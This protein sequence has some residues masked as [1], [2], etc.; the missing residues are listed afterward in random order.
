MFDAGS[1]PAVEGVVGLLLRR[2]RSVFARPVRDEGGCTA[3]AAVAE[4]RRVLH[5]AVHAR[6]PVGTGVMAVAGQW[7]SGR[8]GQSCVGVGDD[9]VVG[10]IAVVLAGSGHAPVAGRDQGGCPRSGPCRPGAGCRT[11]ARARSGAMRSMTRS[12][13]D[14]EIPN[15][16]PSCRIVRFVRQYAATSNMRSSRG[17]A[18]GRPPVG[19]PPP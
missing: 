2:E 7:V 13:A 1:G 17:R 3:I 16:G 14:F 10:G 6:F 11:G 5:G 12:A 4:G 19:L 15:R 8:H 18:H 9:L